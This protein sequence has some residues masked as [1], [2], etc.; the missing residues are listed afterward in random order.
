MKITVKKESKE[1]SVKDP[2]IVKD[3]LMNIA[4]CLASSC[5]KEGEVRFL[6]DMSTWIRSSNLVTTKQVW[7]VKSILDKIEMRS[8]AQDLPDFLD[9]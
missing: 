8:T 3:T 5:I 6:S 2:V 7:A 4:E 1:G 9:S